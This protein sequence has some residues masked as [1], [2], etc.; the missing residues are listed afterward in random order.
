MKKLDIISLPCRCHFFHKYFWLNRRCRSRREQRDHKNWVWV[1]KKGKEV[2]RRPSQRLPSPGKCHESSLQ[3][4]VGSLWE[5]AR[6]DRK[7][8]VKGQQAGLVAV[9]KAPQGDC[10]LSQEGD[11][12]RSHCRQ[13]D[14]CTKGRGAWKT[15]RDFLFDNEKNGKPPNSQVI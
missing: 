9:F 14:P 7:N 12:R 15:L 6:Q 3:G 11:A 2:G 10:V 1:Q 5:A 4:H 13:Q 8:T